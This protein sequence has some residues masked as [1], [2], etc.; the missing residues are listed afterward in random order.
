M[1][2]CLIISINIEIS[3]NIKI[4]SIFKYIYDNES[5]NYFYDRY[6]TYS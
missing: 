3:I 1:S 5:F 4:Y 2:Q 6:I